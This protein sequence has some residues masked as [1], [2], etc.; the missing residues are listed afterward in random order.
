MTL[1]DNSNIWPHQILRATFLQADLI[2]Y[3]DT[4]DD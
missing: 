3:I 1:V 2:L 4:L